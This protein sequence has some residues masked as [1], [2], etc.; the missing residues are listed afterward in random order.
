MAAMTAMRS[1]VTMSIT[2]EVQHEIKPKAGEEKHE[3]IRTTQK[4]P[5]NKR[6]QVHVQRRQNKEDIL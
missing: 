3:H 6:T 5:Q 1:R 4:T 2:A